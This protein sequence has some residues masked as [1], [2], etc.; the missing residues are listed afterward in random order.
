MEVVHRHT[1]QIV[2]RRRPTHAQS[3]IEFSGLEPGAVGLRRSAHRAIYRRRPR[4][5][6][7]E[8]FFFVLGVEH[9]AAGKP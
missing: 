2:H 5:T 7:C 1:P 4:R 8:F 6:R 3:Q 9:G